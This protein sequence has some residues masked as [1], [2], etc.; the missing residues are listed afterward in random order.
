MNLPEVSLVFPAYNEAEGIEK[1]VTLALEE[2]GKITPSFEI[3]VA[4]DGSQRRHRRD[5]ESPI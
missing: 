4:E 1:A 3:I 2:L 5:R